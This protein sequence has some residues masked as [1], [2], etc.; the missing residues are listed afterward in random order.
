MNKFFENW[1]IQLRKGYLELCV[2]AL[3]RR[4]GRLYGLDLLE[5]LNAAGIEVKEGTLYP[6][7][8][9]MSVDKLLQAKWE[10]REARGH[11]RKFYSLSRAGENLLHEM[12]KEYDGLASL[13]AG[14]K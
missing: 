7:L 12:I 11:P 1:K 10:T 9:R 5:R 13:L 2:L 6:I 4:E 14:L 3:I 8:N